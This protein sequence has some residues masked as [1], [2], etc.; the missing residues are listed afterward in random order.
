MSD[1]HIH[2]LLKDKLESKQY[3]YDDAYWQSAKEYINAQSVQGAKGAFWWFSSWMI[4]A[5]LGSVIFLGGGLY[6]YTAQAPEQ[7]VKKPTEKLVN[8]ANSGTNQF[9]NSIENTDRSFEKNKREEGVTYSQ[10]SSMSGKSQD[11]SVQLAGDKTNKNQKAANSSKTNFSSLPIRKNTSSTYSNAQKS[12]VEKT[13]LNTLQQRTQQSAMGKVEHAEQ[14]FMG[15]NRNKAESSFNEF[16]SRKS[17]RK[18]TLVSKD[19]SAFS[20]TTQL[21]KDRINEFSL[22]KLN[23]WA[24]GVYGSYHVRNNSVQDRFSIRNQYQ[25]SYGAMGEYAMK[26]GMHL[27]LGA[28]YSTES[29]HLTIEPDFAVKSTED[30]QVNSSR[31]VV[32]DFEFQNGVPISVDSNYTTVY[33][34]AL[35]TQVDTLYADSVK[36]TVSNNYQIQRIELPISVRFYKSFGHYEIFGATGVNVGVLVNARTLLNAE[37]PVSVQ[38]RANR[39]SVN[40]ALRLGGAFYLTDRL[41]WSVAASSQYE[42]VES[43]SLISRKRFIYGVHS[44]LVYRW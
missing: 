43:F 37:N 21:K 32:Y 23:L 31:Q 12:N 30:W 13:V 41:R 40:G 6:W 26:N 7:T 20:V 36:S 11:V 44:S 35:V 4:W 1:K 17:M 42:L 28:G 14:V 27:Q 33:D 8:L 38:N 15:S 10:Q 34:S 16:S 18:L 19:F 9:N 25:Y 5:L 39:I 2:K 24:V 3:A 22:P 29:F